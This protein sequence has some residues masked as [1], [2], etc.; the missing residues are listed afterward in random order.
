ME[1][2]RKTLQM[3]KKKK[4]KKK[5]K[6][7]YDRKHLQVQIPVG[8]E[9][10]VEN[11]AQKEQKGGKLDHLFKGTSCIE[12]SLGK[13]LYMLRN[14]QG[15]VLKKKFTISRLTVYKSRVGTQ[16]DQHNFKKGQVNST[17]V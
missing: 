10:M 15:S 5:Q 14:K 16:V 11:T 13:G 3:H 12:E 17:K 9:V 2:L 1:R 6:K 8:T 4:K 7:T